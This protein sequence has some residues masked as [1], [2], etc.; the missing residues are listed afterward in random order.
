ML[1]NKH[2]G[3]KIQFLRESDNFALYP[4][5]VQIIVKMGLKLHLHALQELHH[6][7]MRDARLNHVLYHCFHR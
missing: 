6:L 4:F 5:I 7:G 2:L 1:P 3:V